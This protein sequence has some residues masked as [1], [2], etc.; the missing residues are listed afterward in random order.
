[1]ND[2]AR[3]ST[4]AELR[5]HIWNLADAICAEL[6]I[7]H[8]ATL[9]KHAARRLT[10]YAASLA[11]RAEEHAA[12]QAAQIGQTHAPRGQTLNKPQPD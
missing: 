1:M 12:E 9:D 4:L 11:R 8:T 6:T 7:L 3:T 2:P 10:T 5:S